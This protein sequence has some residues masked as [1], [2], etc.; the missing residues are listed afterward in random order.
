MSINNLLFSV[1]NMAPALLNVGAGKTQNYSN[2]AALSGLWGDESST[3]STVDGT[4]TDKVSLTYKSVG[5]KVVSDMAAVTAKTIKQYPELDQDYVIAIIDDGASREARVYR[6]SEILEN[7]QGTQAEKESLKKQLNE[8]PLLVFNSA[9][10]LPETAPDSASQQLSSNLNAFLKS[11]AKTLDALDAAGYDPLA[12]MIGS[13][14]MK[15]IL[16]NCAQ[17]KI[18][19]AGESLLADLNAVITKAVKQYSDL[20]K[21]YVIAIIDD[22]ATREARVYR[23]SE[24]LDNFQGSDAEKADL[25][26]QLENNPVMVFNN[27]NGLPP[28]DAD[29][30][31]QYLA[32]RL[33]EF[34]KTNA[35]TL[36]TLNKA[37]ADPLA[38]LLG[39]SSLK[40]ILA[41]YVQ[42]ISTEAEDEE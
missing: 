32:D 11:S 28:S 17:A 10:G 12:N 24:V 15:K 26:K 9:A 31:S 38:D 29:Q 42:A 18:P 30:A 34:L 2:L 33:D 39:S 36:N 35:T 25:R 1:Q 23:R 27:A 14:T 8:N 3:S 37:G 41:A 19:D 16:A 22:G 7:F 4:V 40:K 13:S 5:D 6:R 20:D 21:D